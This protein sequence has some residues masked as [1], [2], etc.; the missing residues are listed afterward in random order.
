MPSYDPFVGIP[1]V[2]SELDRRVRRPDVVPGFD[3]VESDD[4]AN[5]KFTRDYSTSGGRT[6]IQDE[7]LIT[8][9]AKFR[10]IPQEDLERDLLSDPFSY[11]RRLGKIKE[12]LSDPEVVQQFNTENPNN[13]IRSYDEIEQEIITEYNVRKSLIDAQSDTS[14]VI[15]KIQSLLSGG[16]GFAADPTN[17]LSYLIGG[18]VGIG[19]KTIL[20]AFGKAAT[21]EAGI[22][23]A[24]QAKDKPGE[25]ELREKAGENPTAGQIAGEVALE[26]GAASLF[27]GTFGAIAKGISKALG[28]DTPKTPPKTPPESPSASFTTTPSTPTQA[29]VNALED[30]KTPQVVKGV[31]EAEHKANIL[32]ALDQIQNGQVVDV[33]VDKVG[34]QIPK[35]ELP[36]LETSPN[37][38]VKADIQAVDPNLNY[39]RELEDGTLE[40]VNIRQEL[41]TIQTQDAVLQKLMSC[42]SK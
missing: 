16:A 32:A 27:G 7:K 19:G 20:G 33:P 26:V 6:A 21:A 34:L 41:D 4:W 5:A 3:M 9:F 39:V 23:G 31:S 42:V 10:D 36:T 28:L 24:L 18:S 12:L 37:A 22:E 8:E 14:S 15:D 29:I 1:E 25:V 40:T 35:Q 30:I 13:P 17:L 2:D 38:T 11:G